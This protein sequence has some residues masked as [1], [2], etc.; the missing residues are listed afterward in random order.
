M[1]DAE[2]ITVLVVDDEP[3]MR[4]LT[5]L[6][7]E[8]STQ[9]EVELEILAEAVDGRD[10]VVVYERLAESRA[11]DV[12]VLDYRMP[13]ATGLDVAARLLARSPSQCIILSSAFLDRDLRMRARKIGVAAC[14]E[15]NNI[16]LLPGLIA[17]L[18]RGRTTS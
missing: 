6:V 2:T 16:Q 11:P 14:I 9:P 4:T 8:T 12:V 15:K 13:G 5:T 7:I 10:A 3:D 1:D 18:A 17:Q